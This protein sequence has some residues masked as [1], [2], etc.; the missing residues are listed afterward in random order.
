MWIYQCFLDISLKAT[1]IF[2]TLYKFAYKLFIHL[3]RSSRN[4]FYCFRTRNRSPLHFC[5]KNTEYFFNLEIL[6]NIDDYCLLLIFYSGWHIFNTT[7]VDLNL[8]FPARVGKGER[9]Q[10]CTRV[11]FSCSSWFCWVWTFNRA[12]GTSCLWLYAFSFVSFGA[13]LSYTRQRNLL[14]IS[15][16]FARWFLLYW[17][18]FLGG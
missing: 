2:L 5:N 16:L 8:Q 4:I 14:E 1:F 17:R 3:S 7:G 13:R 18:A 6:C 12:R 11:Y 9:N 15:R 10:I